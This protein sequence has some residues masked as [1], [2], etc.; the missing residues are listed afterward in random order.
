M[1]IFRLKKF[2]MAYGIDRFHKT[3]AIYHG[4]DWDVCNLYYFQYYW[5]LTIRVRHF[6]LCMKW[7]TEKRTLSD[8]CGVKADKLKKGTEK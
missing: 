7:F 1:K 2:Q 5:Y 4:K 6:Y 8:I 3:T